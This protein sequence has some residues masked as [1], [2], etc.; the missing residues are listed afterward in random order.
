M[1]FEFEDYKPDITP[2]GRAISWRE[3]VLLS[4]I[5]HLAGVIGLLLSPQLFAIDPATL[6]ARQA[7]LEAARPRSEPERFVFVNP[8]VDL[9]ALKPPQR[10]EPSDQDREARS[11]ERAK[12]PTNPLPYSRGNTSERVEQLDKQTARGRGPIPDPAAGQQAQA[13]PD[14]TQPVSPDQTPLPEST[15]PLQFPSN[16]PAP[17]TGANG[18][19]PVGG[20]SLGDA[21]RNLQRYVQRDQFENS[22]GGGAFGPA[23]QFDTKGVEFGPWIRRFVAQV[24]RNWLIP[25]AAMS[26]QG[27]VVVTFNVHKDGSITDLNVVGPSSVGAFNSAAYGAL[28]TSNPTAAL[29]PEY[30]AEKA[31][32]TVTFFYNEEPQ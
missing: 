5:V 8:K 11:V 31:F 25:Y 12:Q 10:A 6:Q 22:Q 14:V 26:M 1:Y 2:V 3:G 28:A 24:K 23:I 30:P 9:K 17:Q 7:A 19:R 32:F 18:Q 16:R 15:S 21:L 27:H 20:G 4:I 29:P 13:Q